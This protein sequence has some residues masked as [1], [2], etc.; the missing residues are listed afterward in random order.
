M[1]KNRNTLTHLSLR[2]CCF[3]DEGAELLLRCVKNL[4]SLTHLDLSGNLLSNAGLHET[5][6]MLLHQALHRHSTAWEESLR[7]RF[8]S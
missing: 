8:V 2:H 3:G 4:P 5:A 7:S 1:S 6:N